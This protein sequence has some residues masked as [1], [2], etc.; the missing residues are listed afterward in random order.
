MSVTRE[1]LFAALRANFGS[2]GFDTSLVIVAAIKDP[3]LMG[4]IM[5]AE[6][7]VTSQAK[8]YSHRCRAT[9]GLR[10]SILRAALTRLAEKHFTTDEHE[11]WRLKTELEA[12]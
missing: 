5:L 10:T 7:N 8:K 4:A 3:E 12:A 1:R 11:W 9:G 2:A 6:P